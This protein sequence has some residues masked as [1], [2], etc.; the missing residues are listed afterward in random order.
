MTTTTVL[1][2]SV[3]AGENAHV[4]KRRSLRGVDDRQQAVGGLATGCDDDFLTRVGLLGDGGEFGL[5]FGVADL[6]GCIGSVLVS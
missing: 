2:I 3:L 4:W 6:H 5:D 1:P